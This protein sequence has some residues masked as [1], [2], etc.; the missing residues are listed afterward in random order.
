MSVFYGFSSARSLLLCDTRRCATQGR[1]LL[2]DWQAK[3]YEY[4]DAIHSHAAIHRFCAEAY[5]SAGKNEIDSFLLAAVQENIMLQ[6]DDMFLSLAVLVQP[7]AQLAPIRDQRTVLR[8][9]RISAG[10]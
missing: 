3:L 9:E 8:P 10:S 6:E 4:C 7:D 2:V 5:P 1:R